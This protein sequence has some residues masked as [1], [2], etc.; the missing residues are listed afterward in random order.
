MTT[1]IKIE[2]DSVTIER[3]PDSYYEGMSWAN[4]KRPIENEKS[5]IIA[6][7]LAPKIQEL[8]TKNL[9]ELQEI[10]LSTLNK[11]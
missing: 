7:I 9:H 4:A 10:H 6:N 5:W 1:I 3:D 2:S 8:M 11:K